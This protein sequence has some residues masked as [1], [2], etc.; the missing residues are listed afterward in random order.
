[1]DFTR[2]IRHID[3]EKVIFRDRLLDNGG[4]EVTY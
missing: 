3:G 2:K 1:M 4:R